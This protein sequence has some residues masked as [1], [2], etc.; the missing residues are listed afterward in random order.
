[1]SYPLF[2]IM[3]ASSSGKSEISKRVD[4]KKVIPY[5][6]R[7]PRSGE[8]DGVDAH[9]ISRKRFEAI[10]DQMIISTE[11]SNNLYGITQGEILDL[12]KE[13]M[14]YIIDYE[15][16]TRFKENLK[17]LEGYQNQKVISI[18]IDA[19]EGSLERRMMIQGRDRDEIQARLDRLALDTLAK[20]KTD[21]IIENKDGYI[22]ESVISLQNIILKESFS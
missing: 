3:G 7:N 17:K 13:P 8:V 18:Y 21:Y 4:I 19:P 20:N 15:S 12:E 16:F 2:C 6:S 10:E 22:N 9:F 5:M 1:M 14:I 11:Y